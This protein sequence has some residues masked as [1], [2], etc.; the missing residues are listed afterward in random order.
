M[1]LF[2]FAAQ[3][4]PDAR[5]RYDELC[6]IIQHNNELYYAQAQPEITDAEYDALYRELEAIEAE[7]PEYV[8]PDSPTQRVGNDLSEGFRKVRHPRPMQSIDDI[9]E[10]KPGDGDTDAEL[11]EF[12]TRLSRSLGQDS[13]QV[14]IE[15]KI[16]GCAVTLMYR[17][18]KLEYA[19][20]RGDGQT[21]DDITANILTI[22]SIPRRLPEDAPSLL[23]VRG[24][25]YMPFAD[26]NRLNE[27]R[28]AEGLPALANPRNATAGT[29][30]LLDVNEVA[31]RPLAFLAH[32]L[33]EY[34]GAP[35]HSAA[36]FV[37]LLQ[38]MGIPCNAPII[39][40]D[41]VEAVR[42]AVKDIDA[43]RR[44]LGY[45]TD[46]AVIKL[47]DIALREQLGSTARAPRWAAAFKYLPEQKE[48][49][50]RAI[51]IQVGRT[52]VLTPVAE[53]EPVHLSGTTVSRATLHNQDEISRKDIR[54]GDTV[55]VEKSGEI[56]PAIVHVNKDKRPQDAVPY[57]LFDAVNGVCPCCGEPISQ[58][59]GQVA[60]RCTNFT[61]AAQ[62]AMRTTYFCKR[63]ALDVESLGGTV[64]EALVRTGMIS[65]PLDLFDLTV[66]QLGSLNLGTDDEPRRFGEKNAAKA[67]EALNNARNLPLERWLT[68]FGIPGIGSTN[69]KAY[70][71]WFS[72][73]QELSESVILDNL[74]ELNKKVELYSFLGPQTTRLT[75]GEHLNLTEHQ[76]ELIRE[77]EHNLQNLVLEASHCSENF[78]SVLRYI[79]DETI[80]T[81]HAWFRHVFKILRDKYGKQYYIKTRPSQK[82]DIPI[83][84]YNSICRQLEKINCNDLLGL[85]DICIEYRTKSKKDKNKFSWIKDAVQFLAQKSGVDIQFPDEK[86]KLKDEELE[87]CI[88][89]LEH[90]GPLDFEYLRS[91]FFNLKLDINTLKDD[92]KWIIDAARVLAV[93]SNL[94]EDEIALLPGSEE[95]EEQFS[96]DDIDHIINIFKD[97]DI[98]KATSIIHSL[99]SNDSAINLTAQTGL[100][101][102]K[103]IS[104]IEKLL[105]FYVLLDNC[106]VSKNLE[107]TEQ[108]TYNK[109][110]SEQEVLYTPIITYTRNKDIPVFVV[111]S[112]KKDEDIKTSPLISLVPA[113]SPLMR[114]LIILVSKKAWEKAINNANDLSCIVNKLGN[115]V[116][117]VS[118]YPGTVC[119]QNLV[120]YLR[121]ESGKKMLSKLSSLNINPKGNIKNTED[122]PSLAGYTFVLTGSMSAPRPVIAEMIEKAGGKVVG[123][124]TK[125]TNYL[126]AGEGGGS[127][128]SKA[129]KL[130]IPIINEETLRKMMA[131]SQEEEVKSTDEEVAQ[132]SQDFLL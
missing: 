105:H 124:I 78:E 132:P 61:C 71:D 91:L 44:N 29:I 15:P 1:D 130:N 108:N 39:T 76:K 68:A 119:S 48:T 103:Q 127:K 84:E 118:I 17:D 37:A 33:G 109:F 53:L 41:G 36:D 125:N 86:K 27:Q 43:L 38:R 14:V 70:A 69:A 12:Y 131:S 63:E 7:H 72:N 98:V 28:D 75:K 24:E 126:V 107:K 97:V 35:L 58:E 57:S 100:T 20:T 106:S 45:G 73:L 114:G 80:R 66:E 32:G 26:F 82:L 89:T 77:E 11:V 51:T 59:E 5:S 116:L 64:A 6:R 99:K 113:Y 42:Q 88:A 54:I 52:G 121:S 18:G 92:Y 60:W 40:A 47:D 25:V 95:A 101:Q 111:Y 112:P 120:S 56:I 8:T 94:G 3:Q 2:E 81:E 13:P 115:P 4:Q 122:S 129:E 79:K 90:L 50:L 117:N 30:K 62:A 65:S 123:S 10:H 21:G 49:V 74:V 9:F 102:L 104:V 46:G 31:A 128:R 93:F 83:S 96:S 22:K 34:E 110:K 16:D 67:L 19:A 23:E 85:L 55:L 87:K